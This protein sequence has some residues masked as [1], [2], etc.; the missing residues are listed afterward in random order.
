VVCAEHKPVVKKMS[1]AA[2]NFINSFPFTVFFIATQ[3]KIGVGD[4]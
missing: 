3:E 2:I 4:I 1:K